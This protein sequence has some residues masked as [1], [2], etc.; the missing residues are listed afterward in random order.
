MS[1]SNPEFLILPFEI[2]S[3]DRLTLRHIR[4]LMAIFSWRKKSTSLARV[5]RETLAERTG[6]PVTRISEITAQLCDLG[7]IEKSGN[8]GKSQWVEYRIKD[9]ENLPLNGYQN[10]NGYQIGN[11]YQNGNQTVTDSVTQT[12]T[13]SV[14][15]IDTVNN[16]EINTDKKKINKKENS[17]SQKKQN[18]IPPTLEE[19]FAYAESKNRMDLANKFFDYYEAGEWRDGNGKPVLN[20]KQKF[21]TWTNTNPLNQPNPQQSTRP[22]YRGDFASM[23]LEEVNQW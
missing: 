23:S 4:V 15:R 7:W 21:I 16:T 11:G 20:W 17:P 2:L 19:V 5:S 22:G 3:D 1:N 12:V 13:D 14:T 6:Y 8:G 18:F 10:S 9:V